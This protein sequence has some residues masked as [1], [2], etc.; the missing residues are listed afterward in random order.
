MLRVDETGPLEND[1]K[2][3]KVAMNVADGNNGLPLIR[4]GFGG[5]CPSRAYQKQEQEGGN[6]S[7]LVG[8]NTNRRSDHLPSLSPHN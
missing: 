1:D 7:A 3:I 2:V 4:W 5:P 6:T 8:R